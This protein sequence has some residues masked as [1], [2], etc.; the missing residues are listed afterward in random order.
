MSYFIFNK[1]QENIVGSFYRMAENQSDFNNL[2]I[3]LSSYKVIEDTQENFNAVKYG[4]KFPEKFS[5]NSITFTNLNPSFTKET[6]NFYIDILKKDI[7]QFLNNNLNH[8]LFSKWN[9]Y[10]NQVSSLNLNTITFP[11]NK[12]LE[13]YFNDLGQLSLSPLQIP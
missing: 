3:D 9:E 5:S 7:K 8:P 1:N 6:L 11:L 4:T 2:N 10:Y 12:S 13:Q